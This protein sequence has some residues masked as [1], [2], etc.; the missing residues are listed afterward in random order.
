MRFAGTRSSVRLSPHASEASAQDEVAGV[1]RELA[2]TFPK[3][4][5]TVQADVLS[6]WEAPRGPQR[7][8]AT[9][10]VVLQGIT[11][12]LLLAVCGN[13]ANLL[14]ARA[15]ARRQEMAVRLALGAK[16]WR[17]AQLLLTESLVLA[18]C[19]AALGAGMAVWGT[20]ALNALP[21]MRVRGIPDLVP[22]ERG[23]NGPGGRDAA[24]HRLRGRLRS[25]PGAA[26]RACR[27]AATAREL[28]HRAAQPGAEHP[29]GNRGG[30]RRGGVAGRGAVLSKLQ[31]PHAASIRD[32]SAMVCC[33]PNTT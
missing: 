2:R 9:S 12:L 19:G 26:A 18:L 23:W 30:A 1:M 21:Q 5:T 31:R 24:R 16:P 3:T 20:R 22:D 33:S 11:L 7:L 25:G 28:E 15:S 10:L 29:D 4:N 32:S 6:F 14:L 27:S 17:V 8:L 13:T